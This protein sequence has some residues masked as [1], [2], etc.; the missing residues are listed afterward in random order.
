MLVYQRVYNGLQE[1]KRWA[2]LCGLVVSI[3]F[4]KWGINQARPNLTPIISII[5]LTTIGLGYTLHVT[6]ARWCSV[7][8]IVRM[9]PRDFSWKIPSQDGWEP[10]V[11]PWIGK[12]HMLIW[13][14]KML[15]TPWSLQLVGKS[16]ECLD[17][18]TSD[19]F[20]WVFGVSGF[21]PIRPGS[22]NLIRQPLQLQLALSHMTSHDLPMVVQDAKPTG[23][24]VQ[25]PWRAMAVLIGALEDVW[26][27]YH[28]RRW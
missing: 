23:D 24:E 11:P 9:I 3:W 6:Q 10:G 13:S 15:V 27:V 21:A 7:F 5:G 17:C 26:S 12:L 14:C 2:K 16:A 4:S 1:A 18:W 19:D 25:F 8:T 22:R 28:F 20:D